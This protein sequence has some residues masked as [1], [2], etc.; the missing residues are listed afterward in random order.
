MKAILK[1]RLKNKLTGIFAALMDKPMYI[2]PVNQ[3]TNTI[4]IKT[5]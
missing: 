4:T 5:L 2:T 1:C 3:I